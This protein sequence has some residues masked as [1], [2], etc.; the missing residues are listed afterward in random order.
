MENNKTQLIDHILSKGKGKDFL[1]ACLY[2]ILALTAAVTYLFISLINL[3][4][5]Y[6]NYKDSSSKEKLQ[7]LQQHIDYITERNKSLE[8]YTHK[9][10]S[11]S[12]EYKMYRIKQK[13]K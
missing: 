13:M 8:E 12:S 7:I 1:T 2:V 5:E 9:I 11:I 3:N 4:K 6:L 10:D